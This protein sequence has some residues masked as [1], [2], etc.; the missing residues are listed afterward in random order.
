VKVIDADSG[1]PLV[2]VNGPVVCDRVVERVVRA[3]VRLSD[4][5]AKAGLRHVKL[6][7]AAGPDAELALRLDAVGPN[8]PVSVPAPGADGRLSFL[9]LGAEDWQGAFDATTSLCEAACQ[10]AAKTRSMASPAQVRYLAHRLNAH[11]ADMH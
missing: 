8:G 11:R 3:R 6:V 9:P 4:A 7:V 10:A 5:M 1:T 2:F